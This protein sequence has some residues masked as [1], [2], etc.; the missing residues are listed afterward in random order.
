MEKEILFES[1]FC[2]YNVSNNNWCKNFRIYIAEWIF[3]CNF[4]PKLKNKNL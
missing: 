3:F 4:A 2:Y 1:P